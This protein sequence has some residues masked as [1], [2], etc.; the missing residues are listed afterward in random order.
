MI[1]FLVNASLLCPL[2]CLPLSGCLLSQGDLLQLHTTLTEAFSCVIQILKTIKENISSWNDE[3]ES[4]TAA[5]VRVL[6]AWLAE[7]TLALS[8][9]VYHLLPFLVELC[10][11]RLTQEDDDKDLLKFLVP[12]FSHLTADDKPRKIL[13][14]ANFQKLLL[15]YMQRLVPVRQS[16]R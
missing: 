5:A 10:R 15:S 16:S 3:M 9:D 13:L 12:G 14:K 1:I 7:E 2:L 6:G 8:S 11:T 4:L